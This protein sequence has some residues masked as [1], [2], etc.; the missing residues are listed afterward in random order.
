MTVS[1]HQGEGYQSF[2]E[3]INLFVLIEEPSPY[4]SMVDVLFHDLADDNTVKIIEPGLDARWKQLLASR[5]GQQYTGGCLNFLLKDSYGWTKKIDLLADQY[6]R[7]YILLL[8][9]SLIFHHPPA[10]IFT[11]VKRKH[12]NV[13]FIL[14]HIDI[15][16][17][18][19]CMYS[20][21]L[22]ERG[23]FDLVYTVDEGDAEKY[24][25]ILWNTPYS[26]VMDKSMGNDH[27]IQYHLYY[28]G[29]VKDK[30]ER[31]LHFL[32]SCKKTGALSVCM[33]IVDDTHDTS[34]PA[35][36]YAD[37]VRLSAK[38]QLIPYPE[39][40]ERTVRANCILDITTGG[41]SAFTLR[42]YEAV[43]YNKKLLTDNPNIFRFKYYNSMYMKYYTD[44]K[45]VD[46]DWV[47]D[48]KDVDY[49][50]DGGFS[51]AYLLKDI[52]RRCD[53]R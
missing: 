48:M 5:K 21:L 24:H 30:K 39:V 40:L 12:P 27:K 14:F 52:M 37:M 8:N 34:F 15:V 47:K 3:M 32:E 35:E 33:D 9:S 10:D 13:F 49:G 51:P 18:V 31:L 45:N 1:G 22:R 20:N 38:G 44:I 43:L 26:R 36:Q 17:H 23:V 41:Q 28:C 11:G 46:W 7:V 2:Q 50:Y 53:Q 25:M 16:T 4:N 6:D 42:P 19:S 29:A